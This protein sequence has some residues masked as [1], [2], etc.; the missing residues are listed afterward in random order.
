[1]QFVTR[2]FP[3]FKTIE[4]D[5]RLILK[6]WGVVFNQDAVTNWKYTVLNFGNVL[7]DQLLH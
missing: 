7:H 3:K 2:V 5:T 6:L 4:V 1:M